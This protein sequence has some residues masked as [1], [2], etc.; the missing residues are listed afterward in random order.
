MLRRNQ[1]ASNQR[2]MNVRYLR[3]GRKICGIKER[4]RRRNTLLSGKGPSA[5]IEVVVEKYR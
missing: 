2:R 5:H 1:C 4:Q 3:P